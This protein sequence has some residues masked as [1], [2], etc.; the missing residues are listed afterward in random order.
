MSGLILITSAA[1]GKFLLSDGS[2]TLVGASVS[3]AWA[4][5][6]IARAMHRRS[7]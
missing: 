3:V 6:R 7:V 4:G 2:F 5:I 1:A